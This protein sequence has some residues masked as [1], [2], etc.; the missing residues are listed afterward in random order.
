MLKDRGEVRRRE[1]GEEVGEGGKGSWFEGGGSG[2]GKGAAGEGAPWK[3]VVYWW[4]EGADMEHCCLEGREGG[5]SSWRWRVGVAELAAH[6]EDA[7][8]VS[9]SGKS[10]S[11]I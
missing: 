1:E 11:E 10:Q 8:A 6:D 3:K 4:A 9:M 2:E 5:S 7:C